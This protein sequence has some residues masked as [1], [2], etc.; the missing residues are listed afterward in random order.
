M[1]PAKPATQSKT[2]WFNLAAALIGAAS[3]VDYTPLGEKAGYVI[4]GIS[5][6]NMILRGMTSK[7]VAMT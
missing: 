6:A 2:M 5:V 7:P 3:T 1:E 4:L